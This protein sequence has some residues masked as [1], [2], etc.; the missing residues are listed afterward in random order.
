MSLKKEA[1][2][3][4]LVCYGDSATVKCMSLVNMLAAGIHNPAAVMKILVCTGHLQS[5]GKRDASFLA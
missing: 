2:N 4:G 3:F 1:K 5:G